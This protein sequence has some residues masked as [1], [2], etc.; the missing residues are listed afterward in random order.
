MDGLT[1]DVWG[2]AAATLGAL[3]RAGTDQIEG[4][5]ICFG[6]GGKAYLLMRL[7]RPCSAFLPTYT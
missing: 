1:V 7:P 2:R 6:V 3:S 4:P 5:S